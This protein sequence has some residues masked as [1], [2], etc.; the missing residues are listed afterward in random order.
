MSQTDD[1]RKALEEAE[2]SLETI[3]RA[4]FKDHSLDGDL[5]NIRG[6]AHNR[7]V[8]A[9]AILAAAHPPEPAEGTG[10]REAAADVLKDFD[11]RCLDEKP[12]PG[13]KQ[14]MENLRS[15]LASPAP[16]GGLLAEA[17]WLLTEWKAEDREAPS[18]QEWYR[19]RDAWLRAQPPK[20]TKG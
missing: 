11:D 7:A 18:A 20:E 5:L 2:R 10:L 8:V 12:M 14:V 4:G 9:R 3:S 17:R 6:Y 15:A 13:Q 16:D 19:R 1:L